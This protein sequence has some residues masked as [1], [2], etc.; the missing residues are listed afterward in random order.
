MD[1]FVYQWTNLTLGKIYIGFHKGTEDDGYVCSSSSETFWR[2][3]KDPNNVWERK[4]ISKGTMKECQL[5]ESALLDSIDITSDSVYNNRNSLMFNFNEEVRAK[6]R[7]AALERGKDPEYRKTQSERTKANW[8][9]NPE[10]RIL[11]SQKA[12]Q[13]IRTDITKEKIKIARSKQVITPESRNKAAATI[14]N[15]PNVM[16]PHCNKVGR[17]LGSMKKRHFE[18]CTYNKIMEKSIINN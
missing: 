7:A 3:F 13:Q 10:R 6:L 1:S 18:K 15:T 11:Q 2:E 5:L 8:A 17:Y 12:K 9:A 16:C 4:I 14:K